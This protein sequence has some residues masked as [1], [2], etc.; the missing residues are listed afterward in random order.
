ML[1]FARHTGLKGPNSNTVD[2][3]PTET[4]LSSLQLHY[5]ELYT[6]WKVNN[7]QSMHIVHVNFPVVNILVTT[8]PL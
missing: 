8:F 1:A 5:D 3:V 4:V 7:T 2:L 6:V